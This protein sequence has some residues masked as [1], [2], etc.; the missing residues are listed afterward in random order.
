MCS[1]QAPT[2]GQGGSQARRARDVPS[3]HV[4]LCRRVSRILSVADMETLSQVPARI[5]YDLESRI[6]ANL[7]AV[8]IEMITDA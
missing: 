3:S 2:A 1:M 7:P 4:L 5:L 6:N 8:R